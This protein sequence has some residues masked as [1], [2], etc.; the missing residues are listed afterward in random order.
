[1]NILGGNILVSGAFG[2]FRRDAVLAA[3]GYATD[4]VG[5]DLELVVRLRRQGYDHR[6]P[7]Y[8]EYVNETLAWTEVPDS[9]VTLGRQRDRWHRGLAQTLWRHRGIIG[10]YRYGALGLLALP[11]YL[12]VDLLAPVLAALAVGVVVATFMYSE[13]WWAFL[14]IFVGAKIALGLL[15]ACSALVITAVGGRVRL[16]HP[17]VMVLFIIAEPFGYHQ[18]TVVWRLHGLYRALRGGREWGVMVRH[19]FGKEVASQQ[20][21]TSAGAD[22]HPAQ[23]SRHRASRR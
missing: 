4:T 19:G 14:G 17:L 11:Y 8:I 6:A 9:M 5:E 13:S 18:L 1:L 12:L 3:G 23:A 21:D 15:F 2:L 22:G 16:L 10:S 7:V 20:L